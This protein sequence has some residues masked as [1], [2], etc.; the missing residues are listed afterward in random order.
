M[1]ERYILQSTISPREVF[2]ERALQQSA[3]AEEKLMESLNAEQKKLLDA[4]RGCRL[5]ADRIDNFKAFKTGYQLGAK[6]MLDALS[7]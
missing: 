3:E 5:E 4:H 7:K 1:M 2:Y 6:L